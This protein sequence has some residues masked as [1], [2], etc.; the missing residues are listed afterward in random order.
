MTQFVNFS[1]KAVNVVY[2][3]INEQMKKNAFDEPRMKLMVSLYAV[4]SFSE[5]NIVGILQEHVIPL[6]S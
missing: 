4:M 2:I 3:L 6:T 5:A 1:F